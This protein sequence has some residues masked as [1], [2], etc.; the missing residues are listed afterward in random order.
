MTQSTTTTATDRGA[1]LAWTRIRR[2]RLGQD[3]DGRELAAADAGHVALL[4]S[5]VQDACRW[6]QLQPPCTACQARRRDGAEPPEYCRHRSVA[7]DLQALLRRLDRNPAGQ[8]H[9]DGIDMFAL[10]LPLAIRFRDTGT[11]AED[12]ALFVAYSELQAHVDRHC[13]RRFE[14]ER[15]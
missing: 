4:R 3:E 10:A 1:E 14:A 12:A 8:V 6:L 9:E 13:V 7:R 5:A 15:R 2:Y 11:A